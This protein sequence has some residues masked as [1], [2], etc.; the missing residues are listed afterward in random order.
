MDII[1]SMFAYLAS[2][3]GI[4][5]VLAISAFVLLSGHNRA[6]APTEAIAAAQRPAVVKLVRT[7]ATKMS[8]TAKTSVSVNS[9]QAANHDH[10]D[11]AGD[12]TVVAGDAASDAAKQA[13]L[14]RTALADARR[15]KTKR[16]VA[17]VQR[18]IQ[19]QRARRWAYQQDPDFESRF[20][21]YAD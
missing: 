1:A 18:S 9:D 7:G 4:I 16:A 10:G 21:G 6:L 3:T 5:G 13:A 20:L 8:A 12:V 15:Q 11:A 14:D 19:E 2:V 17:Q